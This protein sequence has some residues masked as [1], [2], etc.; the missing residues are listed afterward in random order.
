VSG[1][2]CGPSS[3]APTRIRVQDDA[4]ALAGII[5]LVVYLTGGFGTGAD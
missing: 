5:L 1:G 3:G 4:I 2:S